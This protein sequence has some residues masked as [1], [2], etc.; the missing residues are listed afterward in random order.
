M[1]GELVGDLLQVVEVGLVLAQGFRGS[2]AAG[3]ETRQRQRRGVRDRQRVACEI[4]HPLRQLTL[5]HLTKLVT[6]IVTVFERAEVVLASDDDGR[7]LC[8]EDEAHVGDRAGDHRHPFTRIDR[9]AAIVGAGF[10]PIA[11]VDAQAVAELHQ[12]ERVVLE[13]WP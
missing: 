11:Q 2:L 5:C 3:G 9:S 13:A 8:T 7:A 6:F 4:E 10:R 1:V 12:I